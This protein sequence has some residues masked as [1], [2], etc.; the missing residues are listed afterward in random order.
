[1]NVGIIQ[2]FLVRL[3]GGVFTLFCRFKE[4]KVPTP[5]VRFQIAPRAVNRASRR[6]ADILRDSS[7]IFQFM[8]EFVAS[9]GF[10]QEESLRIWVFE[11][12][13]D[14]GKPFMPIM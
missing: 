11:M 3:L 2:C 1:M 6:A 12:F 8:L 10:F 13:A 9:R 4:G 14:L 7:G 5:Q